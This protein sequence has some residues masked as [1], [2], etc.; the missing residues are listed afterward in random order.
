MGYVRHPLYRAPG[1][2]AD[3]DAGKLAGPPAAKRPL[4]S[5]HRARPLRDAGSDG[6]GGAGGDAKPAGE[7]RHGE[8][9]G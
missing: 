6:A 4:F 3:S 1:F 9:A 8:R 2:A 5:R 7:R